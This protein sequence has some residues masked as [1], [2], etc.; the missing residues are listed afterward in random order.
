MTRVLIA[1]YGS[2][3]DTRPFIALAAG[4]RARGVDAVLCG[5]E[6]GGEIARRHDVPFRV[7]EGDLRGIMATGEMGAKALRRGDGGVSGL[8]V[9]HRLARRHTQAWIDTLTEEATRSDAVLCSGLATYAAVTAAEAAHRP[10]IGASPVP[11]TPT[12]AFPS[13]FAVPGTVPRRLNRFSH[14]IGGRALWAAFRGPTNRARAEL[15]LAPLRFEWDS[16][17]VLYGFSPSLLPPPPDWVDDLVVCGDWSLPPSQVWEPTPELEEFL[18][19][20]DPPVYI[21][22]GSMAGFD[23][24][25]LLGRIIA[26]LDGRRAVLAGG[27][28]GLVGD[29]PASV[30]PIDRAPHTWLLPRCSVAIHHC[31][32]GTTHAVARAGIPSIAVPFV[33]DQPFWGVLLHERGLAPRPLRWKRLTEQDVRDALAA[34]DEPGMRAVAE[35]MSLEMAEEDGI[36]AAASALARIL[37]VLN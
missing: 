34:T 19:A 32:A 8:T 24:D 11:I 5:E 7:L 21:G 10:F 37:G 33:A 4:L 20:G 26:G 31:G 28:S 9:F 23:A 30:L 12:R 35:S 17:P 25:D 22:F 36:S 6:H 14:D 18:A 15:E 27:W 1:S 2:E 13:V 3:G 16:V 29:L